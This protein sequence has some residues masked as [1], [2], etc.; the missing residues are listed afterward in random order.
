MSSLES[1]PQGG[2]QR[3]ADVEGELDISSLS[4]CMDRDFL[5]KHLHVDDPADIVE[6]DISGNSLHEVGVVA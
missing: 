1:D 2:V 4:A 3:E 5:L 6:M